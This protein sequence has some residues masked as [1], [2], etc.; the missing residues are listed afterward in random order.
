[1]YLMLSKLA[2]RNAK[3]SIKDYVIYLI[4]VTLAFSF[5]FAFNLIGHAKE[6][7]ELCGVMENFKNAIYVVNVFVIIAVCFLINYTTKFM[8]QRRSKEFGTYLILGIKKKQ[9]TNMFTLENIILGLFALLLSFPIGYL[10]SLFASTMIMN[11]FELPHL[12]PVSLS[13]ISVLL[14]FAYFSIIYLIILFLSRRRMKKMKI[15]ELLYYDK[16]NE[17]KKNRK[18]IFRKIAFLFS[19]GIGILALYLFQREFS[20]VGIEPSITVIFGTIL[21][22]IISI[23]GISI[24]VSD[25]LLSFVL[26]RKKLKYQ[27]DHLFIARCFSSKIRTMSF[28]VGTLAFLVTI[29]LVALNISSLFKGMFDYQLELSAPYDISIETYE[30]EYPVLI[31]FIE[32]NY[33]IEDQF[34]YDSYEND[35]GIITKLLGEKRGWREK[36]QVIKL[37]DYNRLLELKGSEPVSLQEDQYLLHVTRELKK[38]IINSKAINKITLENGITL[39]QKEVLTDGYTYAWGA[40]YGFVVVVPD[41][42]VNLLSPASK[43]LIVNTKEETTEAFANELVQKTKPD[44]CEKTEQG[45]YICYSLSSIVVRG[46]EEANNNGFIT[47]TAFICFYLAFIFTAIVGTILAIQGLSDATKYKYRYQVLKN[48]GIN[49][50][51]LNKTIFKQLF[52]FFLFPLLYP[53]VISFCT[54]K[55]MNQMFKVILETE[56]I[57]LQYFLLN[58]GLFLMIYLI[59]FIATYFGFKKNIEE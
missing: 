55:G 36:D 48:L 53:I 10:F 35:S 27:K 52:I 7:L 31:D 56:T 23:Y 57:Y 40:G 11:V 29:T 9:I 43:H 49:A 46:M 17:K 5:L 59:Y 33:T 13:Q 8:F 51:D 22:L 42:A 20:E 19:L 21:A 1:M 16:Q 30:E 25:F 50:H 54:I 2:F 6:V 28:T 32:K 45:S 34:F 58:L 41:S 37:S 12:V 26:K 4:T 38:E 44:D 24:T 18:P 15:V 47:M 14:S 3:R 39:T